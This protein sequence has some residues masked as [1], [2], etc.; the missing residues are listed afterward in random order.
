MLAKKIA[1]DLGTSRVMAFVKGEGV[2]LNEPAVLAVDESGS[3]VL[4]LGSAASH[5]IRQGS[6]TVR[7]LRPVRDSEGIDYSVAGAMLQHIIGRIC[8][9]QR[10]FRPEVIV[11]VPASVTGVE[12]LMVLDAAMHAGA[13]TAYLIDRAV[14]AAI[15][16]NLPVTTSPAVAVCDLGAHAAAV[17]VISRGEVVVRESVPQGGAALDAA[18]GARL[19]E[20]HGLRIT[21]EDAERL[22]IQLGSAV[23]AAEAAVTV[24]GIGPSGGPS[25]AQ[26]TAA[27]V[28]LAM[29]PILGSWAS[30]IL[31]S[32][33]KTPAALRSQLRLAGLI[34]TGG[35]AQL[36]GLATF[37]S[38][39][40]GLATQAAPHPE[41]CVVLGTGTTLDGFQVI[42]R[43][44][45][46]IA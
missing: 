13:R 18:I 26:V 44:Q 22:K 3:R 38:V 46:Y 4:A 17:A 32:L 2:V 42:R 15:G 28:H 8:G 14:A 33:E 10:I 20:V 39:R 11:A 30:S 43:S 23:P 27:E 19:Q 9:R 29:Q 31:H 12:R 21:A 7:L 1:I 35:G 45:H 24:S 25:S 37:I 34:L 36:R 6:R 5:L 40:T 41:L 16:A